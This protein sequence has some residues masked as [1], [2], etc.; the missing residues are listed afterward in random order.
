MQ[1]M[2][3]GVL[4][5]FPSLVLVYRDVPDKPSARPELRV[6]LQQL[7]LQDDEEDLTAA[8]GG[9]SDR[10]PMTKL[11]AKSPSAETQRAE[12]E[13]AAITQSLQSKP[14]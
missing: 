14:R 10:A 4:I 12:A 8:F 9:V 6:P 7:P 5:A 13:A 1:L 11:P 2:M 3:V